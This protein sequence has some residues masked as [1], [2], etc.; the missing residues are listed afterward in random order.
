MRDTEPLAFSYEKDVAALGVISSTAQWYCSAFGA[1]SSSHPVM[2]RFD[3]PLC[4]CV[5]VVVRCVCL[6]SKLFVS[7]HQ[8]ERL[9]GVYS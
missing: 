5:S 2:D 7:S 8:R 4:I 9:H 3:P 6:Q 1:S